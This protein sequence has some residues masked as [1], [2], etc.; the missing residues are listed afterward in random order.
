MKNITVIVLKKQY[1]NEVITTVVESVGWVS[2]RSSGVELDA[3][4]VEL[5]AAH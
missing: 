5:F 2:S 4:P 1:M 3:E